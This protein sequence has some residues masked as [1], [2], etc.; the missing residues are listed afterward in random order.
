MIIN[1]RIGHFTHFKTIDLQQNLAKHELKIFLLEKTNYVIKS[2]PNSIKN[3]LNKS[4]L[5]YQYFL[6]KYYQNLFFAVG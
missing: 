1:F 2:S 5:F 3:A 6:Q 4:F